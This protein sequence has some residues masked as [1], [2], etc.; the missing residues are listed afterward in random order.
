M[1]ER[2]E[3]SSGGLE[4]I[5]L[6]CYDESS[7]LIPPASYTS[8][9]DPDLVGQRDDTKWGA[10]ARPG[11]ALHTTPFTP[12]RAPPTRIARISSPVIP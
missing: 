2:H 11:L 7:W 6:T 4:D 3:A 9:L 1:K 5:V 8:R 10:H 12:G